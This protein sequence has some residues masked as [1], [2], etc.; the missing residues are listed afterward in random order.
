M[1]VFEPLTSADRERYN[2]FYGIC[3][4]KST[5]YSFFALWGWNETDPA[6]LA[7]TSDLCW[8]RCDGYK[9]GLIAPVGN[10]DAV[11]WEDAFGRHLVPGDSILDVPES[12][13]ERFPA[14]LRE[15]LEIAELR[16][17]WEYIY[18]VAELIDLKGG[19]YVHKRAHVKAFTANYNWEYVPLL[20]M[21]FPEL[22][23][24]QNAWLD[25]LDRR[26]NPLLTAEDL[27]IHRALECWNDLPLTGALLRVDGVTV[28]CTIAEEL[29]PEIVDIRFEKA[30]AEYTGIYQALS[31]LFLERQGH[32]YRWVNREEDMGNS[33]LRESK[34]S[35]HPHHFLKKYSVKLMANPGCVI[36]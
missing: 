4:E 23:A 20:P 14:S 29:S 6:E 32:G 24:F 16:D 8:I 11:D 12:L 34:L 30:F 9:K 15:R 13:I 2:A 28:A 35:W 25:R 19:K 33:G 36:E 7:W 26:R 18:P 5:Q 27:S 3:P 21:D 17:E 1:F 31:H 22:L 10:W